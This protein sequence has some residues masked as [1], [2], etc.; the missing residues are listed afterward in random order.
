M[1]NA[2]HVPEGVD[3]KEVRRRLLREYDIEIGG[4]LGPFKGKALRIGLMG[5]SCTKRHVTL[6]LGALAE[7]LGD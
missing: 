2:I 4:G 7:I 6:L 1:L 5:S 3:E